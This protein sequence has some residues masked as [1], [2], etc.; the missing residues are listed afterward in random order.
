M[1]DES[2]MLKGWPA[3]PAILMLAVTPV[4]TVLVV[5]IPAAWLIN[6]VFAANLIH[7]VFSVEHLGYWR[8]VGLFALWSVAKFKIKFEGPSKPA[9]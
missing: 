4:L 8:V 7:S 5:S 3:V 1:K 6:H 2:V 9:K